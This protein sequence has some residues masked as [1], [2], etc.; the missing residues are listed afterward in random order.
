MLG[1]LPTFPLLPV[2][3]TRFAQHVYS[4]AVCVPVHAVYGSSQPPSFVKFW[5]GYYFTLTHLYS[6]TLLPSSQ[7]AV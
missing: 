7:Y 2:R 5:F 4:S 3:I 1:L 6:T